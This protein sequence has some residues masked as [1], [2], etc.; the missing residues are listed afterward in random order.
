MRAFVR[1]CVC[2][3]G[4]KNVCDTD[5]QTDRL[6][7]ANIALLRFIIS[8]VPVECLMKEIRPA[9]HSFCCIDFDSS[10]M[11]RLCRV[12]IIGVLISEV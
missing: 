1:A 7:A 2:V 4:Y 11:F 8:V 9:M 10:Y 5:R 3:H 12:A 6:A